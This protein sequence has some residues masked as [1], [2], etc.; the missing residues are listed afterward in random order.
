MIAR[1]SEL[2]DK[3]VICI[4]DGSRLG[5]IGEFEINTDL[6]RIETV[7]IPG[8]SRFFGILGRDDDM[9]IP[10]SCIEVFGDEVILINIEPPKL[11][12]HT[13]RTVTDIWR[14]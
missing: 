13:K 10:F 5:M 4:K 3:E 11:R 12:R 8:R 1:A 6:G 2:F 14:N 9:L 7:I